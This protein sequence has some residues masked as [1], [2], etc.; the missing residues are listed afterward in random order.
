MV[1]RPKSKKPVKPALI[2]ESNLTKMEIR[3]L[4]ALRKSLGDEI[5]EKAFK[6]WYA[7]RNVAGPAEERDRSA[8]LIADTL[9]SLASEGR[10]R[11]PRGGYLVTRGRGRVIV[12]RPEA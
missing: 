7:K 2:D 10:L 9:A 6:A 12:S 1:K 3:K 4:N 8:E 11:I 5:A